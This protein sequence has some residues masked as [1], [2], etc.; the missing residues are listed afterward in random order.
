MGHEV[1]MVFQDD[2]PEELQSLMSLL[3]APCVQQNVHQSRPGKKRQPL[4]HRTGQKVGFFRFGDGVPA[5]AH[6]FVL[7]SSEARTVHPD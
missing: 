3:I 4:H 5:S 2:I 6:E 1:Q 7:E